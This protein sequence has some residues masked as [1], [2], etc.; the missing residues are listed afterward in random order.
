MSQM[1]GSNL[2]GKCLSL[3]GLMLRKVTSMRKLID[4]VFEK[5]MQLQLSALL[6]GTLLGKWHI[7]TRES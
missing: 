5:H 7:H 1:S 3:T 6:L 4:T 2:G